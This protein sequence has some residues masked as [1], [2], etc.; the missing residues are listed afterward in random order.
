MFYNVVVDGTV[1][2]GQYATEQDA[3][4][5]AAELEGKGA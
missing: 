4:V 1:S 3:A 2:M 5:R